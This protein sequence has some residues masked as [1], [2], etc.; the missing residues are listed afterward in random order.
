MKKIRLLSVLLLNLN[1]KAQRFE[2]YFT[3]A[4]LRIDYTF[5]G[6]AK[7]QE[8]A[9]DKLNR[10][11]RWYGKRRRL[12]EVPVEGNGQIIVR[13]HR[14]DSII[15]KNSFST[16]S[17]MALLRR[18]QDHSTKFRECF[19]CADAQRHHRRDPHSL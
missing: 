12:T 8:I 7:H 4:T 3:D 16:L 2:D 17:G 15:Y 14:S 1:A 19:P 18:S 10:S 6:N 11:P 9:L 13:D 5:S